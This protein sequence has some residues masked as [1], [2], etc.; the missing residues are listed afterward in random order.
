MYQHE[1]VVEVQLPKI[2]FKM[3]SVV[4][5]FAYPELSPPFSGQ[6]QVQL[7]L[8]ILFLSRRA[9]LEM[10]WLYRCGAVDIEVKISEPRRV[11]RV[12]VLPY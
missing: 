3:A 11:L 7:N 6:S 2:L 10:R 12:A 8:A 5:R 1:E 9:C 4:V